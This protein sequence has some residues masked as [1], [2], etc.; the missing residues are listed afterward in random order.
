MIIYAFGIA[1]TDLTSSYLH[2]LP[3]DE[4]PSADFGKYL[5]DVVVTM[6][7]LLQCITDGLSWSIIYQLLYKIHWLIAFL[8]ALYISFCMLAVLNAITGT[9]CQAAIDSAH[10]DWDLEVSKMSELQEQ[11]VEQF[12]SLFETILH[13]TDA[14]CEE[15][16]NGRPKLTLL[17]LEQNLADPN[18]A[19][20]FKA[21]DLETDNAWNLFKLMSTEKGSGYIYVDDFV[22]G[23]MKLKG[24][25]RSL[26]LALLKHDHQRIQW[27]LD[28]VLELVGNIADAVGKDRCFQARTAKSLERLPV[29]GQT[30]HEL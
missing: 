30:H 20:F 12:K 2:D 15:D 23:C 14:G 21:L 3:E 25:A 4:V 1:V 11:Q 26:D 5:G 16:E 27:R 8:F 29:G 19:A 9:F 24:T 13:K 18:M 10:R 28:T 7:T 6:V 22:D 17:N